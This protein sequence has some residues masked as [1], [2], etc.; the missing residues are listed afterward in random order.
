MSC[1]F[2]LL[3]CHFLYATSANC[4]LDE[5]V[6]A[7]SYVTQAPQPGSEGA[8]EPYI[9]IAEIE[10]ES[11]STRPLEARIR[12]ALAVLWAASNG[13]WRLFIDLMETNIA[14]K[15]GI[16]FFASRGSSQPRDITFIFL[17][18]TACRISCLIVSCLFFFHLFHG[19]DAAA[20]GEGEQS[21]DGSCHRH[22]EL[23]QRPQVSCRRCPLL[24]VL[25]E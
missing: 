22:G 3:P 19:Y 4:R 12:V 1:S 7:Y 21:M 20:A 8:Q 23:L 13:Q 5:I 16:F 6:D 25:N 17:L 10:R 18:C 15:V 14:E 2:Y 24:R 11:A 9:R